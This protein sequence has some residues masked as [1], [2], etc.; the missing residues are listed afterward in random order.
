MN[1]DQK[2]V[3]QEGVRLM[4][5]CE[6]DYTVHINSCNSKTTPLGIYFSRLFALN[7]VVS[8]MTLAWGADRHKESEKAYLSL[9]DHARRKNRISS[10]EALKEASEFLKTANEALYAEKNN[11]GSGQYALASLYEKALSASL[12]T[13]FQPPPNSDFNLSS[14]LGYRIGTLLAEWSSLYTRLSGRPMQ[15]YHEGFQPSDRDVRP[16][17]GD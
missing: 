8:A 17:Q 16:L 10:Q 9:L 13:G 5:A 12:G 3:I 15:E 2:L 6:K 1:A 4:D 11:V 14:V 7:F